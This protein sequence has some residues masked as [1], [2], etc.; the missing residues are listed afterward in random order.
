[1]CSAAEGGPS[2]ADPFSVQF[3]RVPYDVEAEIAV[4]EE[5]D[6]PMRDVWAVELRTAVFRGRQL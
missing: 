5:L 4:A 1:M 6:M 2:A 3:V